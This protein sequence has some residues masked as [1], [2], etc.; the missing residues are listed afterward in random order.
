[1]K[2][3]L[4]ELLGA[5]LIF[6]IIP[7]GM[8]FGSTNVDGYLG[9]TDRDSLV[10]RLNEEYDETLSYQAVTPDGELLETYENLDKGSSTTVITFGNGTSCIAEIMFS[11]VTQQGEET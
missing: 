1:M 10:S 6:L 3:F 9:C 11:T 2:Q 4:S 8:S 7:V 5:T